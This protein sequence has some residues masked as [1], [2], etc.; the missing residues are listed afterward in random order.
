[1]SRIKYS[2]SNSDKHILYEEAVQNV[3]F[4]VNMMKRFYRK[5]NGKKDS[6]VLKE[7]FCGTFALACKWV[8]KNKN[9]RAICVDLDKETLYWGIQNKQKKLK[10]EQSKRIQVIQ[11]NV[12]DITQPKV[13]IVAAF[14][15][16]YWTFSNTK[17]LFQYFRSAHKS[18]KKNGL[19]MLDAF[20][21]T[22]AEG[23]GEEERKCEGFTYIWEQARFYPVTREM[24]CKIHFHFQDGTKMRNAFV[25]DW[26]LWTP[27]EIA[28]LLYK[29][30]FSKVHWYFEG[31]DKETEEG[32]GIYRETKKGKNADTWLAYVIAIR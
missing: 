21:G 4:E 10:S 26:R 6:L 22:A 20:G 12:L 32:N 17:K 25:Y 19:L 3:E 28:E 24:Q 13:D 7:D 5:Y 11:A 9:Y 27:P 18:L 29:A 8:E 2:A 14:N 31:T 1:M 15:F 23:E 16:S 30:G